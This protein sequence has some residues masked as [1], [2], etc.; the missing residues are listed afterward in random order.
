MAPARGATI[1]AMID[2]DFNAGDWRRPAPPRAGPPRFDGTPAYAAA[3]AFRILGVVMGLLALGGGIAQARWMLE[4]EQSGLV[5]HV[6]AAVTLLAGGWIALLL[7]RWATPVL[8]LER[9]RLVAPRLPW[10]RTMPYADI[11]H[12]EFVASHIEL[13]KSARVKGRALVILS[14]REKAKPISVFVYD[15]WPMDPRLLERLES[16]KRQNRAAALRARASRAQPPEG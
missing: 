8:V 12:F 16:A 2:S 13:D 3:P 1:A 5:E 10:R 15:A 4:G 6:L 7:F 11:A 9:D 14:S